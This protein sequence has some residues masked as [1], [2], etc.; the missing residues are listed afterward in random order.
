MGREDDE[1][2]ATYRLTEEGLAAP[3]SI[4]L[5]RA[6]HPLGRIARTPN[7]SSAPRER[8]AVS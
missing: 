7:I 6:V 1:V 2:T 3:P 4:T 5:P 8:A